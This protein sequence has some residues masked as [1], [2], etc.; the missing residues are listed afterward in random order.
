MFWG[1]VTFTWGTEQAHGS[2]L[3]S[4][5]SFLWLPAGPFWS[6]GRFWV[7]P[8]ALLT[9][10]DLFLSPISE[11]TLIS[12]TFPAS[13]V[14][15]KTSYIRLMV[16]MFVQIV[17]QKFKDTSSWWNLPTLHLSLSVWWMTFFDFR[18]PQTPPSD[19]TNTAIF[20][21]ALRLITPVQATDY[22]TLSCPQ[23]SSPTPWTTQ[24]PYFLIPLNPSL[25]KAGLRFEEPVSLHLV[26]SVLLVFQFFFF[27]R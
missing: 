11:V 25:R 21:R 3:T 10:G 19:Y 13:L 12:S 27:F 26:T 4:L 8:M 17:F 20:W 16:V 23:P 5:S 7:N 2:A 1:P 18:R 22:F 9:L 14:L 6:W 24:L 15:D